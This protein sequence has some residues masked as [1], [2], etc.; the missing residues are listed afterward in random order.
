MRDD[1]FEASRDEAKFGTPPTPSMTAADLACR[2]PFR[3][4][5]G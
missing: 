2:S 4:R 1:E 5:L 3:A